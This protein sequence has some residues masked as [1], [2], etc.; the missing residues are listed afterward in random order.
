MYGL[1]LSSAFHSDAERASSI[2]VSLG[3]ARMCVDCAE[4][5][6]CFVS[7]VYIGSVVDPG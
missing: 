2:S 4:Q 7:L 1:L 6:T 3:F 5:T